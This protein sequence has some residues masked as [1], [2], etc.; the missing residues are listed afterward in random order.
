MQ[1]PS[2]S[3]SHGRHDGSSLIFHEGGSS[4]KTS[5][6]HDAVK[7]MAAIKNTALVFVLDVFF[8]L[9]LPRFERDNLPHWEFWVA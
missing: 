6:R 5:E 8:I 9:F 4:L 3:A 7:N 2:C 1:L